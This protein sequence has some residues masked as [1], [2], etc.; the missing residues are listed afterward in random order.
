MY[1]LRS[2]KNNTI[3]LP[4]EIQLTGDKTFIETVLKNNSIVSDIENSMSDSDISGSDLDC[5]GLINDSDE[6]SGTVIANNLAGSSQTATSSNFDNSDSNMQQL[7]NARILD[8]LDKIGQRL[9]RIENKE[10]KKTA[11]KTKVKNSASKLVKNKKPSPKV[12]QTAQKL[13]TVTPD[14]H[15]SV[16]DE[17]LLQLKVD[18]RL[19]ELSDLAKSGTSQ[20]IK[21]QRGGPVDVLIKNRVTW[22]H[23]YVL[24]GLNKERVSYDQLN[25]TQ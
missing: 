8:Q 2:A 3:E 11:D 9:D 14:Q 5:S 6:V 17:T 16:A 10:C 15:A 1:N 24:S 21:S 22:P 7:I 12:Q 19:R 23:E 4:V 20:K 25:V 13:H 18:Q